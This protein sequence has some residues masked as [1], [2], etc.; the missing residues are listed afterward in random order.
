MDE[1]EDLLLLIWP[2]GGRTWHG[3]SCA[4]AGDAS[5][6]EVATPNHIPSS[7]LGT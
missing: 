6:A 3:Q 2:Q 4:D 7:H 1:G 5:R